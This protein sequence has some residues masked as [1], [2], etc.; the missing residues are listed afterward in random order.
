MT[1]RFNRANL[2]NRK[3]WPTEHLERLL[4]VIDEELNR[5]ERREPESIERGLSEALERFIASRPG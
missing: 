1:G 5:R 4:E 2:R 3:A